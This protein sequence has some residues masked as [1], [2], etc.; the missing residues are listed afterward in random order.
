MSNNKLI[1]KVSYKFGPKIIRAYKIENTCGNQSTPFQ[2]GLSGKLIIDQSYQQKHKSRKNL[3]Y[4]FRKNDL[5]YRNGEKNQ[6]DGV[7]QEKE[8]QRKMKNTKKKET[9][10]I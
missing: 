4:R 6:Y 2:F 7:G 5:N 8:V 10:S 9:K 1:Q 3:I